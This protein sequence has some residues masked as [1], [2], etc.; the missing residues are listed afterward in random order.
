VF[1]DDSPEETALKEEIEQ[2]RKRLEIVKASGPDPE[3]IADEI[4]SATQDVEEMVAELARV[5]AETDQKVK[6]ELVFFEI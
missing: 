2:L 3:S 4:A 6:R 5:K 1:R